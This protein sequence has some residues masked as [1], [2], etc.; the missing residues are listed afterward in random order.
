MAGTAQ[1]TGTAQVVS[2]P[3]GLSETTFYR[4]AMSLLQHVDISSHGAKEDVL[5]I[6]A[7]LHPFFYLVDL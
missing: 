4:F 5:C 2:G 1:S 6:M 7:D 3:V